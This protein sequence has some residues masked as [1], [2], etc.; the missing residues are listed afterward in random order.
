[1]MVF[2]TLKVSND[3][4]VFIAF[5]FQGIYFRCLPATPLTIPL[6]FRIAI[7]LAILLAVVI[8]LDILLF[9]PLAVLLAILA[10]IVCSFL[11]NRY[12]TVTGIKG[13]T[14]NMC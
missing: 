11:I 13:S 10:R 8:P 12:V 7:L 4:L 6:A 5:K 14:V 3:S 1:M 2:M 9:I